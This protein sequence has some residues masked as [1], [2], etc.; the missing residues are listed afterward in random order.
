MHQPFLPGLTPPARPALARDA[1]AALARYPDVAAGDL[2]KH[3][4]TLGHGGE[5][6]VDCILATLGERVI[7]APEHEQFDRLVWLDT[8]LL[9]IQIKT[10]HV[11]T[12]GSYVFNIRRGYQRGPDGTRPYDPGDFD[13]LA[14][15]AL[16]QFVV[17]FTSEWH[18]VQRIEAVEIP[19]L[20]MRPRA[21]FDEALRNLGLHDA[22]PDCTRTPAP[23]S[24]A[25]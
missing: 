9:R 4:K 15:V 1:R 22:I 14:L 6:L 16:P 7:A 19:G 17:K 13:C 10:R 18:H 25:A 5:R 21:S 20:R 3:A 12:G 11:P 2:C 8:C 23:D 24:A